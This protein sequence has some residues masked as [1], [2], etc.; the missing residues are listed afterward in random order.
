MAATTDARPGWHDA[1]VAYLDRRVV[2]LFFLG[3]AA[4]LPTSWYFRRSPPGCG[5]S[6]SIARRSASLAGFPRSTR[7]SSFGR[8]SSTGFSDPARTGWLGRRR[9]WM[10]LAQA[11]IIAGLIGMAVADPKEGLY[12][13]AAAPCC[14]LLVRDPGH[15]H[16]R[17]S[18]RVRAGSCRGRWPAVTISAIAWRFWSQARA[19]LRRRFRVRFC[20]HV[21]MA[22]RCSQV[23]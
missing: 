17:L 7:S 20:R 2:A 9:S 8:R 5:N 18:Y 19:A 16:R 6:A 14:R 4:G 15:R 21:G 1:L 3:I 23:H 12:R 22:L 10:L 13:L 11:G